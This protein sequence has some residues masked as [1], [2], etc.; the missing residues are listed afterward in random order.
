MSKAFEEKKI[1]EVQRVMQGE[2]DNRVVIMDGK[3]GWSL[4][5]IEVTKRH[6]SKMSYDIYEYRMSISRDGRLTILARTW[7]ENHGL[8]ELADQYE[9]TV[10]VKKAQFRLV[11]L[12]AEREKLVVKLEK[13]DEDIRAEEEKMGQ[14]IL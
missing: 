9:G 8:K 7:C 12:R 6:T 14:V 2:I 5:R 13:L 11:D 3:V 10:V 1:A 4:S